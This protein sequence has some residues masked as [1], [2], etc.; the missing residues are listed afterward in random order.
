M[1]NLLACDWHVYLCMGTNTDG[2]SNLVT[3]G[4]K[5]RV[6]LDLQTEEL[7]TISR[8]EQDEIH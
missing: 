6:G 5:Y 7:G 3:Q 4:L 8:S 1:S 2:I